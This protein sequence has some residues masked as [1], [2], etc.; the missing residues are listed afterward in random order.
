MSQ[1]FKVS[2]TSSEAEQYVTDAAATDERDRLG[3]VHTTPPN[4][5]SSVAAASSVGKSTPSLMFHVN[6]KYTAVMAMAVTPV[7]AAMAATL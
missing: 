2:N 6:R 3:K 5:R 7:D 1:D 4:V